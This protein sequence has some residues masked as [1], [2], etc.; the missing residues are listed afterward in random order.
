MI[1]IKCNQN[2]VYPD[3]FSTRG[4]ARLFKK[5][6]GK[7]VQGGGELYSTTQCHF[8]WGD[9]RGA[10]LLTGRDLAPGYAPVST[11]S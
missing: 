11:C 3:I 9:A 6:G 10:G 4:V 7:G 1:L 8:I 5:R 2:F